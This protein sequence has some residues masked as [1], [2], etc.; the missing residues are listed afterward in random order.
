MSYLLTGYIIPYSSVGN[1][2]CKSLNV[3]EIVGACMLFE[4]K[5]TVRAYSLA[6]L[7]LDYSSRYHS[8]PHT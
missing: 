7:S 6:I 8:I 3:F 4:A 2:N 1:L 5:E